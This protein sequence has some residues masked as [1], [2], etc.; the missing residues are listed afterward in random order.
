[1]PE[2]DTFAPFTERATGTQP[3]LELV[4][5]GDNPELNN[6]IKQ[7][8]TEF[9]PQNI[10]SMTLPREPAL[11]KPFQIKVDE[12]LWKV[13]QNRLPPR[14]QTPE[15]NKKV[16]RQIDLLRGDDIIEPSDATA[17]SQVF[18]APEPHT[19]PKQWRMCIH[20]C[21]LNALTE[22]ES[23]SLPN[24]EHMFE[25]IGAKR[26]KFFAVMDFTHGFHQVEVHPLFR[27]LTAFITFCGIFQF[28][29]V[30]FG[31]KNAPSYFQQSLAYVVLAISNL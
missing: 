12:K 10:F 25:R 8:I 23:W 24:T 1:M 11:I 29:R 3:L 13:P 27:F 4:K 28:K 20:Y 26:A 22:A 31:P 15:K 6:R 30:P 18:L 5:L 19:D 7:L 14:V 17:Y 21:R 9:E 2:V 16:K